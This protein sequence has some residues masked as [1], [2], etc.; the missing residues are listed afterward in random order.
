[1][2]IGICADPA[3]LATLPTP[4]PFDFIE[5]HVQNF[6]KPEASEAEF[7]FNAEALRNCARSMPAANCFLPADLRVTGP[8]IDY[9]RLDRYAENTFRRAAKIGM[10]I[11]VFDSAGAR[12]VPDGFPASRAF[13]QF[14]DVLRHFAPLAGALGVTLVVKALNREECNFVNTLAE[15]AEAVERAAHPNVKLLADIFHLLRNGENPDEIVKFGSLV[16]HAHVAENKDHAP[17]GVNQ[18]DL[19]PFLRALKKIGFDDRLTIEAVWAKLEEQVA[20]AAAAL[21]AQLTASGYR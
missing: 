7:S 2:R 18:E 17:P 11:I 21:R 14:V 3:T 10:K 16:H 15:A 8:L 19:R 9:A 12:H 4:L 1:M 6:L 13:E 5:G 20:P